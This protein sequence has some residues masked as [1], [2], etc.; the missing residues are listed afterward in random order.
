MEEG[1]LG[2]LYSDGEIIF[3]EGEVGDRMFIVES[4][5]VRVTRTANGI[6]V[7]LIE[8]KEG[9]FFGEMALIE[10]EVRSATVRAA[11]E[12]RLLSIDKKNFLRRV[13]EDPSL[14]Y[15]ILERMSKRVRAL[16]V[17]LAQLKAGQ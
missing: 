16:T 11:G 14:A 7:F 5:R 2:K 12:A 1:K 4:G 15:R 10:R 3:R 9:D 13:H 8:L 17:E 6:D